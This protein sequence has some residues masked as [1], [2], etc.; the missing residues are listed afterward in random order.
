MNKSMIVCVTLGCSLSMANSNAGTMGD[1]SL[2]DHNIKPFVSVEGFPVWINAGSAE[3]IKDSTTQLS[4]HDFVSG[5]ARFAGG[6]AYPHTPNINF[7]FDAAW[8]YFGRSSNSNSD[9][10]SRVTFSGPD[11]LLGATYKIKD[12]YELF[13]KFGVLFERLGYSFNSKTPLNYSFDGANYVTNL[14]M[15]STVLDFLPELKV[16]GV[17]NLN[18]HWG[19]SL[20]YMHAFGDTPNFVLTDITTTTPGQLN[21]DSNFKG[22]SLNSVLVGA[23]YQFVD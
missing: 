23:R 9:A 1:V 22:P 18:T 12:K 15:K 5:G 16:G 13:A 14:S 21:I 3:Y 20:A 10:D 11:L 8:N 17:Y 4:K 19:V 2:V 6:F 7:T